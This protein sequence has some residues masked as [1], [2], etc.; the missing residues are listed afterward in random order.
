[1]EGAHKSLRGAAKERI[2]DFVHG[3]DGFGNTNPPLAEARRG[4][5]LRLLDA[6][7]RLGCVG[8]LAAAAAQGWPA[9]GM[10]C[11][12]RCTH[13]CCFDIRGFPSLHLALQGDPA[14]GSAAEFIVRMARQHPGEVVVL[15]LAALTN[16]ALALHVE[17]R[18]PQLL[19]SGPAGCHAEGRCGGL[20]GCWLCWAEWLLGGS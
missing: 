8:R 11:T 7:W 4:P 16:V 17:P 12:R 15:A 19:V 10:H 1:M 3:S 9:L 6:G 18:L 5:G 13:S 2:A 14:P 20:H